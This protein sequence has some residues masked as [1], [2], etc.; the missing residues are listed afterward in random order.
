VVYAA[1]GA[2]LFRSSDDGV[3]Y[4]NVNLPV[5]PQ[6]S[7]PNCTG[8]APTVEGCFL[9]DI[10]TDVVVRAPGGVGAVTTGGAVLAAVGWRAGAK[11]NTSQH[12]PS[13]VEA[14][15][16][17]L[18]SSSDGTP[19]S[20]TK[21]DTTASNF[22]DGEQAKIGRVE[23][24]AATGATQ[25]HGYIYAIVQDA[26]AFQGGSDV[27]GLDA[28]GA[29]GAPTVKSTYLKGVYSSPD[30]GATWTRMATPAELALPGTGS[31]LSPGLACDDPRQLYCPGVQA[32]Y[33]S[34]IKP[35]PTRATAAGVPIRLVFGLEE[36]WENRLADQGV[37]ASGPTPF[38]VIAPSASSWCSASP[39]APRSPATAAP[40]CTPTSTTASSSPTA[41]AVSASTPATTAASASSTS[42]RDR[43]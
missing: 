30:F 43:R 26:S 28:P 19:G 1:T 41:T 38:K 35:D 18:Y 31:T 27:Y 12:Y 8:A 32:W 2:G 3:S 34:W 13:Y 36:L 5:S 29:A 10:V 7:T 16:N 9:A 4:T 37:A 20:F 14:P 39:P 6:G 23:L 15:G 11:S 22:A 17:G 33:N 24:G 21:V 25:D 40:P 42:P